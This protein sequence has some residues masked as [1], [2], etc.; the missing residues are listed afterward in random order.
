MLKRPH[1]RL[2]L[3]GLITLVACAVFL[4]AFL[5]NRWQYALHY[6]TLGFIAIV[7]SGT[8][9]A[10]A[11]LVFH[12]LANNRILTP[13]I[14]G[15]DALYVLLY[16]T[17]VFAFGSQALLAVGALGQFVVATVLMLLFA[18]ALYHFMLKGEQPNLYFLLLVG[19][20]CGTF[21]HSLAL[22]MEVL[23]DPN[24]FQII[25]DVNF[26]SINNVNREILPLAAVLVVLPCVY[27]F[28]QLPVLNVLSLGRDQAI[29]L[30][31]D[32]AK[33]S[34]RLLLVVALLTSVATA[35]IGPVMFLG[36]LVMNLTFE[37][38]QHQRY[39][40]LMPACIL[41][42]LSALLGGQF[43]ISQVLNFSTTITVVIN[44]VGGIY[45]IY[46]LLRR[47]LA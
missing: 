35:L 8:A 40:T 16:T 13:S 46:L 47:N 25:Q 22:F 43:L 10:V 12:T 39:Q 21:F 20:I 3:L 7:L 26:A 33:L 4:F 34:K 19:I 41:I 2:A 29:T 38:M 45:F 32:Y 24:E 30:G 1:A 5:P 6:R 37:F 15:L 11:T 17:V 18:F 42:T 44:F 31:V 36:L 14:L 9:I 23:I 27:V 28:R